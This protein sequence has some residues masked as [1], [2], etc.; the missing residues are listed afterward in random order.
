MKKIGTRQV[1]RNCFRIPIPKCHILILFFYLAQQHSAKLLKISK[2][3][4]P[5]VQLY[6]LDQTTVVRDA[7]AVPHEVR[8]GR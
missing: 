2:S 6:W 3:L 7:G 1:V 5:S 4:H 8:L